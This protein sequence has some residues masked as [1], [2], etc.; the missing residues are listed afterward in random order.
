MP[1]AVSTAG[2]R[3]G[4]RRASGH[5][6]SASRLLGLL[7]TLTILVGG[8]ALEDEATAT[9]TAAAGAKPQ[10][11]PTVTEPPRIGAKIDPGLAAV[12]V[13]SPELR[14]A[15]SAENRAQEALDAAAA[16]LS[17][18]QR[19]LGSLTV[20]RVQT[21]AS[22]IAA[23]EAI[24]V[25]QG[26]VR[27]RQGRFRA[28]REAERAAAGRVANARA[29]V[30]VVAVSSYLTGYEPSAQ[31]LIEDPGKAME[32]GRRRVLGA[33]VGTDK[34]ARVVIR[35]RELDRATA[36]R[37]DAAAR[38]TKA[39][40][41][42][43]AARETRRQL[44]VDLQAVK[45]RIVDAGADE[46]R[47]AAEVLAAAVRREAAR[48]DMLDARV[49]ATVAG[50]DLPLVALDA[51][52]KAAQAA[53]CP[54]GW[55]ALA[56]IGRTE[57]FHGTYGGTSLDV[58]GHPERKI[59]GIPLDGT[60]DTAV[61]SDTDGGLL[62]GDPAQDRAVGPMQ[63]IPSTWARWGSDGD[64]DGI[65]DPHSIYDAAAAAARYLCASSGDLLSDA[66]LR[67]AYFSYNH[68]E[69][70]VTTVLERARTYEADIE[71]PAA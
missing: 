63:F 30:R 5:G 44:A 46:R 66:G 59:I 58:T 61:V 36:A 57:S 40:R 21:E 12:A 13:S 37:V 25:A 27:A 29:E 45:V 16:N 24:K 43:A 32:A 48:L 6:R 64:G 3:P 20:V 23:D 62:D 50:A 65:N 71:I 68:S 2:R 34:V 7:L 49:L 47:Q 19:T 42:L 14:T 9:A 53:P 17:G 31:L 11:D 54:T 35:I 33:S 39:E 70:Y 28:A 18:I 60:R 56:G 15:R 8:S 51:Y 22:L 38:L 26:V 52:W 4:T 41:T 55:W 1:P 10:Q 69:P 67:R